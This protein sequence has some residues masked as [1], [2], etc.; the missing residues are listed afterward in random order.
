MSAGVRIVLVVGAA[1]RFAG[2]VVSALAERG[3]TVRG[4]ARNEASAAKARANGAA[5]IALG[6][7]GDPQSLDAAVRGVVGVFHIGPAFSPHEA[8]FGLNMVR[9][10]RVGGVKKFVFSSVIQ[11]T[12]AKL[13]NHASKIPVEEALFESGLDYTILRPTNFLQNLASAW[14]A[15]VANGSFGEPF[16]K[17]AAVARVDYRDVAEAAAMAF[18]DDRLSHG[19]FDLCAGGSPTREDIVRD[20]SEVLGRPITALEPEFDDWAARANLPYD[21][22]QKQVLRQTHRETA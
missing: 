19:A 22:T 8:E 6:D 21:Q 14:P 20:M 9:A 11:P 2:H 16:P 7:L 1:G 4:L 18:I 3:F 5:Q 10:A 12:Y 15:V 17:T 13:S